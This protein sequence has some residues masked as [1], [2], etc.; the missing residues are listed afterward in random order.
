MV[1]CGVRRMIGLPPASRYL[2]ER[3]GFAVAMDATEIAE[4][5]DHRC[6]L[7]RVGSYPLPWGA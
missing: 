2:I 3:S 7:P 6:R 4:L 5:Q 1:P